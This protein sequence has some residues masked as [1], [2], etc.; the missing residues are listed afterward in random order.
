[1]ITLTTIMFLSCSKKK[2]IQQVDSDLKGM[3]ENKVEVQNLVITK[4]SSF[5]EN[6]QEFDSIYFD[7][8]LYFIDDLF[9]DNFKFTKGMRVDSHNNAF[10]YDKSLR[11][12]G[13]KFGK[14]NVST[15]E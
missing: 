10:L 6:G 15:K 13:L 1:M 7:C 3:L 2:I 11:L 4:A 5:L 8:E 9:A 12:I 14:T